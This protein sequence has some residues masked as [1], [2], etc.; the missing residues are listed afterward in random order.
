MKSVYKNHSGLSIILSSCAA[1]LPFLLFT[2]LAHAATVPQYIPIVGIPGLTNQAPKDLPDYINRVYF[3]T[4]TIG[5]LYGVVKIAFAGVKYSM[6]DIITSKESAKEDIQ[7]VLLGLA[8]LLIPFIVLK[9]I[10]PNLVNL[11]VLSSAKSMK[12]TLKDGGASGG[13]ASKTSKTAE[14]ACKETKNKVW[15]GG[16]C[17]PAGTNTDQCLALNRQESNP[18]SKSSPDQWQYKGVTR[19]F[20][21]GKAAE[22][23]M[24]PVFTQT[25]M[26]LG[27]CD[28]YPN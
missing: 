21:T 11:D 12:T 1:I 5:A 10:N 15:S 27:N 7:G 28:L 3:L 26:R 8:I 17:C 25:S 23:K 13:T 4:V 18:A 22:T 16:M 9:E 20:C 19:D 24:T 6:S 14:Q 2:A